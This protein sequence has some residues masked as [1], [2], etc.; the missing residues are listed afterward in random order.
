MATKDDLDLEYLQLSRKLIEEL[1]KLEQHYQKVEKIVGDSIQF[2]PHQRQTYHEWL[3][4]LQVVKRLG[5]QLEEVVKKKD[6]LSQ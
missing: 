3:D 2:T 6:A 5:E 1:D 4:Q